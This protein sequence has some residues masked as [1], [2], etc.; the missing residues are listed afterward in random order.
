MLRA[1][2][3]HAIPSWLSH[4]GP[5]CDVVVSTRVS[6]SRNFAYLRFPAH[7]SPRERAMA[8]DEVIEAFKHPGFGDSFNVINFV[9]LDE[10]QRQFLAEERL[11]T[12]ELAIAQGDRG[13]I[14]DR[15][16]RISVMVN[17]ENHITLQGIG[18]GCC[19]RELWAEIDALDDAVGMR[20]DYAFDNRRGFLTSRPIEAGAG[21]R[22]TFLA[23]LP[24]LAMSRSIDAVLEDA[25]WPGVSLS[26]FSGGPA[27]A[28]GSLVQL[29]KPVVIGASESW[30]CDAMASAMAR[31]VDL[32]R[33]ARERLLAYGR[34]S[35][36]EKIS[37]AFCALCGSTRLGVE[38]FLG[39]SSILR[40][41]IECT[42]FDKCTIHD[43]NRL[44]LFILPA[45]LRTLIKTDMDDG[46]LAEARAA[47][48]RSFFSRV[49][50]QEGTMVP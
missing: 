48:V 17:E 6:V 7:A 50:N 5:E 43:L 12:C 26:G 1:V 15:P 31:I 10:R 18:P 33:K 9:Q 46:G 35:L 2:R 28:A 37:R 36:T 25:E 44:T 29:S 42:L 41:G 27:P 11:V 3:A 23:D 19:V 32:E 4:Q 34:E 20:V 40:L 39:L 49:S 30:F 38:E 22:V 14:C 13:V 45:H 47:M 24:A 8:F 21:L 16:G